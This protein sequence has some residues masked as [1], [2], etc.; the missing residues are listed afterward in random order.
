MN[1]I[2]KTQL[3]Q[4]KLILN[5]IIIILFIAL[6]YGFFKIQIATGKKYYQISVDNSIRQITEHPVRG[7]IRDSNGNILVDNRP[8]F[9]VSVIPRQL[10]KKTKEVLA[11]ILNETQEF[12]NKKIKG[13]NSFRPVIIKRDLEYEVIAELEERRLDLPGVLVEVESKRFYQEN[14]YSPH[15]FG[16]VSEVTMEESRDDSEFEPGELI[17]KSGLENKYDANLRGRKIAINTVTREYFNL[18]S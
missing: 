4:K 13:R 18:T 9:V 3:Q 5:V 12:V 16:Y 15:I 14:V 11:N 8:S 17:G 1:E 7:T 10:S 2:T 6:Y